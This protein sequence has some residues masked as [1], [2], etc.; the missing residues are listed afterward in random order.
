MVWFM[1]ECEGDYH[2]LKPSYWRFWI[3][4]QWI[5]IFQSCGIIKKFV[6]RE[7][8]DPIYV[9]SLSSLEI[10]EFEWLFFNEFRWII[11]SFWG[12]NHCT[13]YK[14][15]HSLNYTSE[16]MIPW[17]LE[18]HYYVNISIICHIMILGKAIA[19]VKYILF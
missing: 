10:L 6:A 11:Y 12:E 19:F 16:N 5:W 8:F 2:K 9:F 18:C 4:K 14:W 1:V 13:I 3:S 17:I 7:W 15:Q